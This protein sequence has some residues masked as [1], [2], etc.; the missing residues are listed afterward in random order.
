MIERYTLPEMAAIWTLENKFRKWLEIEVYAC[1]AWA[2][3]G[4]V[5]R[6]AVEAIAK[7]ATFTVDRILEIEAQTRHD[8]VAFTRCVSESL[9]D[10]S[11]YVH[12]GLTSS[13]VVDTALAALMRDAADLLLAD[14]AALVDVLKNKAREHK[15][16]LMM[17]R[18]HGVH[19]EPTTFGLKMALYVAEMERNRVRVE[20]A[21]DN[22]AY[23]KISGAV[24]TYANTPPF[25]EE[26]VCRKMGLTP[27][28]ISTQIL[29]RDRHAE[30]MA[31][32]AIVAG[33]LD[34]LATEIR[35]LQKTETREV[36][37]PF[38]AGQKG[39][40]AMPHKRNPVNC[41]QITGLSRI[42]RAN[43]LVSLEN[44]PLWHERDISHSS[45]ERITVPDSTI[46]VNYMLQNMTRI[47]RDLHVYPENMKRNMERTLGLTYSQKVL[48]TLV[49]KGLKREKAYDLVQK[50]A[51]QAWEENRPFKELLQSDTMIMDTLTA[52]GLNDCF[53]PSYHTRQVE[54][55]FKKVGI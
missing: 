25:V 35:G 52:E 11:K 15:H 47:I 14:I 34:K 17:G 50:Y 2:E 53:D 9:G 48:L 36:E 5:P 24:G 41:E 32:L 10:E 45:A 19:A 1:E 33:T 46:L 51:M 44:M 4:V 21:R 37:E 30:Y 29:Q 6:D 39:S 3:L 54:E 8:V 7:K 40:S 55:I 12:Y 16:T 43:A 13:D 27:A 23:G 22:I 42:V 26:Y 31:T 49:E 28:P 18:T 20:R 38:Y